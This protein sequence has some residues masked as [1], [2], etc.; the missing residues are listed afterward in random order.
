MKK[1]AIVALTLIFVFTL[2]VASAFAHPPK[3]LSASWDAANKKITVTAEHNVNDAA[4]HFILGLTVYEGNKQVLQKQYT[5]Q[6]SAGSFSDSFVLEGVPS[7]TVIRIQ[8]VCNIMGSAEI[9]FRIP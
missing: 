2:F 3:N 5:S 8:M 4:K 9:E 1:R 7:G 6:S